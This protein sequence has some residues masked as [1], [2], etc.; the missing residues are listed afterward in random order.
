MFVH[1]ALAFLA[2]SVAMTPVAVADRFSVHGTASIDAAATDNVF[3]TQFGNRDADVFFT[4]RPGGLL[5]YALPRMVHELNAEVELSRYIVHSDSPAIA[6]RGG[7]KAM[8]VTG[9]RSEVSLQVNA[10]R[11]VLSAVSAAAVSNETV[12]MLQPVG[13]VVALQGDANEYGS[14]TA[15]R[16]LRLSQSLFAR[17][18]DTDD[19]AEART[20]GK[21]AEAGG[22]LALDRT[23]LNNVISSSSQRFQRV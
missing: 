9:P 14:Y 19:H 13:E 18:S 2:A 7:W 10:S 11:S 20:I 3:S 6:L 16:E 4:V 21:S 8:F 22:T 1:K 5:T 15:T 23:F 12:V 17:G